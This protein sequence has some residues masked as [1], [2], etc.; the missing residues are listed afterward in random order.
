MA[1]SLAALEL[2]LSLSGNPPISALDDTIAVPRPQLDPPPIE[3]LLD[4]DEQDHII[5]KKDMDRLYLG[6]AAIMLR[7]GQLHLAG[8]SVTSLDTAQY[9]RRELKMIESE[10][11]GLL[12]YEAFVKQD[13]ATCLIGFFTKSEYVFPDSAVERPMMLMNIGFE[14]YQPLAPGVSLT[15]VR[16]LVDYNRGLVAMYDTPLFYIPDSADLRQKVCSGLSRLTTPDLVEMLNAYQQKLLESLA[17]PA[18][19]DE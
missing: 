9:S 6:S 14:R 13:S 7:I 4:P 17:E 16:I 12:T 5:P 8:V 11:P 3:R 2:L 15:S 10:L 18:L 1:F 19:K